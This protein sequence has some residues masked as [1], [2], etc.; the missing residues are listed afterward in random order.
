MISVIIPSRNESIGL[1]ATVASARSDLESPGSKFEIIV[2]ANGEFTDTAKLIAHEKM[3]DVVFS[4]ADSP[5]GARHIGMERARGRVCFFLDSHVIVPPGFFH[6]MMCD[7]DAVGAD[8]MHSPHRFL[9]RTSYGFRVG[10]D[11]YLWSTETVREAPNKVAPWKVAVMG[12]GAMAVRRSSYFDVGGYWP[13]L[14]GFGGEE[15]Q[16]NLKMWLSGKTCW[17]TPNTHHWHYLPSRIRHDESMFRDRDFVRNFLMINYAYG[18]MGQMLKAHRS[19][20][21]L[22][23]QFEDLYQDLME[24]VPRMPEVKRERD[25]IP[26]RKGVS[27]LRQW[28]DENGVLN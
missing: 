19:F 28:F 23:W 10:W 13:A 18:G 25:S 12:H 2:V 15:T 14:K 1:W 11:E 24:E 3:A 21:I 8:V 17:A 6:C 22:H 4:G 20:R 16:F 9:S 5:Q 26:G 7:M 27:W